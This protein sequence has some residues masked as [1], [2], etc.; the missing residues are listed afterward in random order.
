[1]P[2]QRVLPAIHPKGTAACCIGSVCLPASLQKQA[3][4]GSPAGLQGPVQQML[5]TADRLQAAVATSQDLRHRGASHH[6]VVAA[7]NIVHDHLY[8]LA[9]YGTWAGPDEVVRIC[10][11]YVL[12]RCAEMSELLAGCLQAPARRC[13][14]CHTCFPALMQRPEDDYAAATMTHT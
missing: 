7:Y 3:S 4:R 8:F 11:R 2:A 9:H 12:H 1:M 5:D 10:G 14:D 13:M 6:E